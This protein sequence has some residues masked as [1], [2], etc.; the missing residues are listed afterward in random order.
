MTVTKS[1]S[2]ANATS[3]LEILEQTLLETR[4]ERKVIDTITFVLEGVWVDYKKVLEFVKNMG[5]KALKLVSKNPREY[6]DDCPA[7]MFRQT[8]EKLQVSTSALCVKYTIKLHD[9]EDGLVQEIAKMKRAE[10]SR[11]RKLNAAKME[12]ARK[13]SKTGEITGDH[14]K[15]FALEECCSIYSDSEFAKEIGVLNKSV[16]VKLDL[17]T[18]RAECIRM[19]FPLRCWVNA[20][21]MPLEPE[22]VQKYCSMEI[23]D[24]ESEKEEVDS[25]TDDFVE[26]SCVSLNICRVYRKK[27]AKAAFEIGSFH[28]GVILHYSKND[29]GGGWF[30]ILKPL[31]GWIQYSQLL[32]PTPT[33]EELKKI[34]EQKKAKESV[35]DLTESKPVNKQA[36]DLED[37]KIEKA[38]ADEKPEIMDE[39]V[40]GEQSDSEKENAT[41]KPESKT[42]KNNDPAKGSSK[43]IKEP[44]EETEAGSEDVASGTGSP[45]KTVDD[46]DDDDEE[47]SKTN[48]KEGSSNDKSKKGKGDASTSSQKVDT[49]AELTDTKKGTKVSNKQ[50]KS[51]SGSCS[52][53]EAI[54]V[55]VDSDIEDVFTDED[56][57]EVEDPDE[58]S[59]SGNWCCG[60]QGGCFTLEQKEDGIL[61]GYLE[62]KETCSID[63][64][65]D[66][67]K[68]QFNQNWQKGSVHGLGVITKV[69]G[70]HCDGMR[71]MKVQFVFTNKKGKKISGKNVMYKEPSSDLSGVWYSEDHTLGAF[72]I[73]T[74]GR[75]TISG[76]VDNPNSCKISGK[77][78]A[79]LIKFRQLW[80]VKATKG[81]SIKEEHLVTSVE[82]FVNK[83]GTK[84]TLEY[85]HP[86]PDGTVSTGKTVLRKKT[87]LALAGL[88]V[89]GDQG[90]RFIFKE[91]YGQKFSGYLE[92]DDTCRIEKGE[93]KGFTVTF[94]QVWLAGSA[95]KGA[96][97]KVT[98][99]ADSEFTK[100]DLT[101]CCRKTGGKEIKGK[102]VLN[103]LE[104][105]G[106]AVLNNSCFTG[107]HCAFPPNVFQQFNGF[108]LFSHHNGENRFPIYTRTQKII[109]LGEADFSFTLAMMR[110]FK[111]SFSTIVGTSY[112]LKWGLGKPPPSWNSNPRIRQFLNESQRKLDPTL[113]EII[114][115]GGYCRFGVDARNLEATLFGDKHV[116]KWCGDLK[117]SKFDRIIFPFPRAS[118]TRFDR[119]ADTD[120]IRGTFRSAQKMLVPHGE[121]HVILHTS[122]QGVAQFDL[123]SIRALAEEEDLVWRAAIPFDPKKMP[124]YNPK[125]V[126]G[127]PW[128]PYEPRIHVFTSRFSAWT[129]EQRAWRH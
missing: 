68:V 91:G 92:S 65:V 123:W 20:E 4:V 111:R 87:S 32:P 128:R 34:E 106:K 116:G 104:A 93:V 18:L 19:V 23:S 49:S 99:K 88:W 73:K 30:K 95:H 21:E 100:L 24:D 86:M 31:Q 110:A 124:A 127:K 27:K 79:H 8:T 126:T 62:K 77:F 45:K 15:G 101:Y 81:S 39:E 72:T 48:T 75:G 57:S 108:K 2:P 70:T 107:T 90:G 9:K 25:P 60:T 7:V 28:P 43:K 40:E 96:V 38:E 122:R 120:L 13:R 117:K 11:K 112:M 74:T 36:K 118:L 12:E 54:D 69:T 22:E 35:I 67:E 129:P 63:G 17:T 44:S 113:D 61:D 29:S 26:Q 5:P 84:M 50:A 51:K 102:S 82:G 89:S 52:A 115:R 71:T 109:I 55:T 85:S 16:K 53:N 10:K 83:K 6:F 98:G 114:E 66:G 103:K 37:G 105:G 59:L 97:A 1:R 119:V 46:N 64:K 58:K 121:L 76:F 42:N 3:S 33:E 80:Q 56:W 94:R 41:S 47:S 78:S 14:I 125:D